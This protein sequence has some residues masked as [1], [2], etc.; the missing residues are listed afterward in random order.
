MRVAPDAIS[1]A[2]EL[3]GA[4]LGL[5]AVRPDGEDPGWLTVAATPDR[6]AGLNRLLVTSGVDV[7]GLESGSDLEHLFLSL[8]EH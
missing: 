1:R 4:E 8:T 5:D 6:A 3:L 2:R 7:A